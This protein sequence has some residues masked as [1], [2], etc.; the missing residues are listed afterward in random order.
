MLISLILIDCSLLSLQYSTL[1]GLSRKI[2]SRHMYTSKFPANPT[3][4]KFRNT[5]IPTGNDKK[6]NYPIMDHVIGEECY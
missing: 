2:M 3:L 5:R 4:I 1:F 6:T